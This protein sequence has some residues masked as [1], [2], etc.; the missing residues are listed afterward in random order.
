MALYDTTITGEAGLMLY[1]RL[2]ETATTTAADT[3]GNARTATY[4]SGYAQGALP[5]VEDPADLSVWLDGRVK[6]NTAIN[7]LGT[8]S[9]EIW[10]KVDTMPTAANSMICGF[11]END[12]LTTADKIL[13]LTNTGAVQFYAFDPGP[14]LTRFTSVPATPI[15]TGRWY[16]AVGTMDGTAMRC[17]LQ[18]R[19]VGNVT[20][21]ST[22]VGYT[23]GRFSVG[24][25]T[26]TATPFTQLPAYRD[27]AAVYSTVLTP[28]QVAAH[29]AAGVRPDRLPMPR[30]VLSPAMNL[31]R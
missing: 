2:A 7:T 27:E 5:A 6:G 3:S 13:L 17:Y 9:I 30:R 14:S 1:W 19:E 12:S 22:F 31:R 23:D 4:V 26:T 10:F 28:T 18:G 8:G 25:N 29:Y 15:S 16:H 11:N 24:Y 21:G 20:S